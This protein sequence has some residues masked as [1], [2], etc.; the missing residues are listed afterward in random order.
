MPSWLTTIPSYVFSTT[1][2]YF[3][4]LARSFASFSLRREMSRTKALNVKRP[5]VSTGPDGELDVELAPVAR[6]A[7]VSTLRLRIPSVRSAR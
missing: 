6:E 1:C 5:L 7:V 2:R 3:S 4:S